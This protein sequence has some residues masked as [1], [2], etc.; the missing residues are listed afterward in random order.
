MTTCHTMTES[1]VC[2]Y[3]DYSISQVCVVFGRRGEGLYGH[4][5]AVCS[6]SV[7]TGVILH[8]PVW[9]PGSCQAGI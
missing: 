2:L 5:P 6:L 8:S 1:F 4:T 7:N 3:A 9:L